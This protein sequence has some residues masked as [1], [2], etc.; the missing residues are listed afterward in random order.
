MSGAARSVAVGALA[1]ATSTALWHFP[2]A[3]L[4]VSRDAGDLR[5][6]SALERELMGARGFDVDTRVF[7]EAR[8]LIPEDATYAVL[9]GPDV[10]VSTP[11]TLPAVAPFAA[12]WLL[13]RRQLPFPSEADWVVSYGGDIRTLGLEY[14]RVVEVASGIA[15]AEIRR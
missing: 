9:T 5:S 15:V 12:Y 3:F 14:A 2:G 1:V 7:V 11:T 8:R 10:Q 13:P 6:A 4:T